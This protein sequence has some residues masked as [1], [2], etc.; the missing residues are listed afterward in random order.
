MNDSARTIILPRIL[1]SDDVAAAFGVSK[2]TAQTWLRDS[3]VPG[4]K[5]RGRWYASREQ[6]VEMIE[7]MATD[8]EKCKLLLLGEEETS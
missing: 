4:A 2:R 1:Q 5:L 7:E 6:L 3:I 8:R